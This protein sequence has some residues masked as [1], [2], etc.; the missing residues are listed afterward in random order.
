MLPI[1]SILQNNINYPWEKVAL[2]WKMEKHSFK[3]LEMFSGF[4]FNVIAAQ[5][6]Q[7]NLF[8]YQYSK[9]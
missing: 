3:K 1:L 5:Q 4:L 2:R 6:N 9:A 7:P 8:F